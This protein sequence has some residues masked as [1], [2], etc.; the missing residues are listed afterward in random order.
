M[1][2]E[3]IPIKKRRVLV[4]MSTYNGERYLKEQV[5][6][7]LDQNGVA[8][9]LLIRDDGSTDHTV[10]ILNEY[11]NNHDNIHVIKG[12]NIGVKRSFFSLMQ[13]GAKL[14]ADYEVNPES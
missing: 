6:S 2:E 13:E 10:D 11:A 4:L 8:I 9:T 5:D 14:E 3:N 12:K 1:Q 7:I